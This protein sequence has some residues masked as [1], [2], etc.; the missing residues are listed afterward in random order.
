T[1]ANRNPITIQFWGFLDEI[2]AAGS[3]IWWYWRGCKFER[4]WTIPLGQRISA[5]TGLALEPNPTSTRLSCEAK[6]LPPP[7]IQRLSVRREDVTL[8]FA[9]MASRLLTVP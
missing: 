4:C 2:G 1:G 8:I 6:Y 7:L 9:P 5:S 3:T